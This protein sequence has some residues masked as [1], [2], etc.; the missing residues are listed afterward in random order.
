M[1]QRRRMTNTDTSS[2]PTSI[3]PVAPPVTPGWRTSEFWLKVAALA[4]SALFASGALTNDTA[5]AIAGMA[6][7]VLTALGYTV[8]RTLMKATAMRTSAV[9]RVI[10]PLTAAALV[11][12]GI[13]SFA[14]CSS[15]QRGAVGHAL[16]D[17]TAPERAELVAA[18]KPFVDSAIDQAKNPDGSLDTAALKAALAPANLLTEAGVVISCA[19]MESIASILSSQADPALSPTSLGPVRGAELTRFRADMWPSATF[20][21]S[22]GEI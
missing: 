8:S 17:C 7:T 5:L 21:T 14:A 2:P 4:L 13:G 1:T 18:V 3:D 22:H 15:S 10:A 6:A 12:G 20:K 19:A 16:W 11:V 9:A